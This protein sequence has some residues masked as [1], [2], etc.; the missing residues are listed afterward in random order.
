MFLSYEGLHG[1]MAS[2]T[3]YGYHYNTIKNVL[4]IQGVEDHT[5]TIKHTQLQTHIAVK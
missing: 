2:F 1:C 5:L 3:H 4:D